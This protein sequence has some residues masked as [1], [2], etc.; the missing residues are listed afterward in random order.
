VDDKEIIKRQA[1]RIRAL[2]RWLAE[3]RKYIMEMLADAKE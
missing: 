3:V 1:A 2:E